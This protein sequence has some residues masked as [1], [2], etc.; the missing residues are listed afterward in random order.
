MSELSFER[1]EPASPQAPATAGAAALACSSC[2]VPLSR[3]FDVNGQPC[4]ADCTDQAQKNRAARN[5][6]RFFKAA[7]Y[8]AVA[9]LL[10]AG[11][12]YAV[13]KV[14]GYELGI[15]AIAVGL[16]VGWA[17]SKGSGQR[18]G[19]T[20]QALA[21]VCTYVAICLSYAP[22]VFEAMANKSKEGKETKAAVA[23]TAKPP[24]P[25]PKLPGAVAAPSAQPA[26]PV[27]P[28]A[29]GAQPA[30]SEAAEADASAPNP[31]K[32][33][34]GLGGLLVALVMLFGLLLTLPFQTLTTSP[35][36]IVLVAIALYEAWKL[37]KAAP[38]FVTGP[39]EVGRAPP[40]AAPSAGP[41]PAPAGG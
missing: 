3:Y 37:N 12:Y 26:A 39:L 32:G 17:V 13:S 41:A 20:Y 31:K 28:S 23:A 34:P 15:I 7:V 16:A 40:P 22:F 36:G 8:G 21:M 5:P 33:R 4:C 38:L 6:A 24:P 30:A 9:S 25:A 11:L 27:Q 10:S 35:M 2:G 29:E 18:G 19:A 14:T 1:A